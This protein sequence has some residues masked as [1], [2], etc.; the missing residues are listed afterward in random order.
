MRLANRWVKP[1]KG[2]VPKGNAILVQSPIWMGCSGQ[3]RFLSRSDVVKLD[4]IIYH[5]YLTGTA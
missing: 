4:F 2:F 5:L 1:C 3:P